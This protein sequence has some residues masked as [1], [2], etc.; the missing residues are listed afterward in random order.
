MTGPESI[1]RGFEPRWKMRNLPPKQMKKRESWTWENGWN[2]WNNLESSGVEFEYH[3]PREL[4]Y[5]FIRTLSV[6][7][8]AFMKEISLLFYEKG[9]MELFLWRKKWSKKRPLDPIL[10]PFVAQ[11]LPK[12]L[13]VSRFIYHFFGL[14][15]LLFKNLPLWHKRQLIRL[16]Q[17]TNFTA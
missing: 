7:Q 10:L 17:C 15:K 5:S 9:H 4:H 11:F 1:G 6:L 14:D 12:K 2:L 3:L 16:T 8:I 13:I